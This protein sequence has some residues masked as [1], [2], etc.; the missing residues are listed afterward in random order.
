[1]RS[2][3]V[4]RSA[5]ATGTVGIS[6]IV[7]GVA[8]YGVTD[9]S[10]RSVVLTTL[11]VG[12]MG[13]IALM[14][15]FEPRPRRWTTLITTTGSRVAMGCFVLAGLG[16]YGVQ[17]FLDPWTIAIIGISLSIL[18]PIWFWALRRQKAQQLLIVGDTPTLISE[19]IR[20][21]PTEP[22]GFLSP[23]LPA[24][25]DP[26]AVMTTRAM[27]DDKVLTFDETTVTDGG[28]AQLVAGQSSGGG[29]ATTTQ[30]TTGQATRNEVE[31]ISSIEGVDR[32]SGLSRLEHVLIERDVDT[33]AVG[34]A[35]ADR[36][37]FF[38]VLRTC[39][40]YG[41]D[42]LAG[43]SVEETV[44]IGEQGDDH[45]LHKVDLEPW[46]WHSRVA[47]R[48][49]DIVFSVGGLIALSPFLLLIAALIKLDSPG[50]VF[51]RQQRTAELGERFSVLK[52]RSM[53]PESEDARPGDA[54]D[55]IT[56]VG[57]VLR[58]THMDEI[59]QLGSILLGSMSVVGPRAAWIEEERLLDA[60]VD[61]W[62]QRW[63]VKPGLTGLAQ[64]RNADST[65]G[66]TKL[67]YDMEYIRR[68]SLRLDLAI[69]YRQ[70]RTVLFD[71]GGLLR[72]KF[73]Q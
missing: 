31:C 7:G 57:R 1:M 70:I 16:F 72:T 63:H 28:H 44:L 53:L 69:V 71:V 67:E 59:P 30:T 12:S 21:A 49:F 37:E 11:L 10:F 26:Q 3:W 62:A 58:K 43:E 54:E 66:A 41:V 34:F 15:M 42:V 5:A 13:G 68:Q 64:I 8:V 23:A 27:T 29:Q 4:H 33:V 40:K 61:G 19:T 20:S 22:L 39:H 45:K 9:A 2:R 56:R 14:S 51:Y 55:R 50:P 35:Y 65:D 48:G 18:L 38:G 47:K 60:E 24:L 73:L 32:V 36:E 52:F 46:P 17:S 25:S 6:A